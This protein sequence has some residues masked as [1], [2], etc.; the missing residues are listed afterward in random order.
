MITIDQLIQLIICI[1]Y[2]LTC[3][4]NKKQRCMEL[5]MSTEHVSFKTY[6]IPV[7]Q[8]CRPPRP[9]SRAPSIASHRT[10]ASTSKQ[11]QQ[12]TQ[13]E[14]NASNSHSTAPHIITKTNQRL[15]QAHAIRIAPATPRLAPEGLYL[16]SNLLRFLHGEWKLRWGHGVFTSWISGRGGCF[17]LRC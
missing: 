15:R 7:N 10:I 11:H 3:L 1:T 2:K 12:T 4:N 8:G 14:E 6:A 9:A 13:K 5:L 16:R 17:I